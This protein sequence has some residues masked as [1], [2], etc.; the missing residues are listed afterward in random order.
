M[1]DQPDLADDLLRGAKVIA[2]EIYG[3]DDRKAIR[4]LYH[5]QD[6][7]PIFQLDESGVF[8]ALRSRIRAHL[9]AKSAEKEARIAA[10]AEEVAKA[11]TR[12]ATAKA[13]KATAKTTSRQRR[14]RRQCELAANTACKP[15][16]G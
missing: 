15:P 2:K 3:E 13:T 16:S 9:Q 12:A 11:T 10:A 4:R 14:A 8:F 1:P 5:E 7:W 6:R